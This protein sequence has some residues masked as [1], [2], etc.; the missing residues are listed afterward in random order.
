MCDYCINC[1]D[2]IRVL[3]LMFVF[4]MKLLRLLRCLKLRLVVCIYLLHIKIE[5]VGFAIRFNV[6]LI[7]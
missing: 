2:Y 7:V 4:L 6:L 1:I 5:F 3:I